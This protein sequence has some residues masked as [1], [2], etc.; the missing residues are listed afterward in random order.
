MTTAIIIPCYNAA[1]YLA[2]TL[3]S[4]RAQTRRDWHLIVVDDGSTDRTPEIASQ[5]ARN[6]ARIQV[7]RQENLG[8]SSAR[9][10]GYA[11]A[12][13][14]DEYAIFLDADD[15]WEPDALENLCEA[16]AG[17][18]ET[19]AAN[20]LHRVIDA[21]GR[22]QEPKGTP[23]ELDRHAAQGNRLIPWPKNEPAGFAALAYN[24]CIMTPGTLLIRRSALEKIALFDPSLTHAED[25]D[26][27]LRLSLIA[28]IVQIDR[29]VLRYRQHGAGA[30]ASKQRIHQG[31][32]AVRRKLAAMPGLSQEQR[33]I[34]RS[35]ARL[36]ARERSRDMLRWA[37]QSLRSGK[38][39]SGAKQL[40]HALLGYVS[41]LQ[42]GL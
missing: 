14:S 5:L 39:G 29:Y 9:N 10:N 22:L 33:R 4:V 16:L 21:H 11:R 32:L 28:P 35:S 41:Y 24:N 27:W 30:S 8:V 37:G 1:R 23:Y 18:P 2:E 19:P 36:A 42:G 38:V 25:W 7:I 17:A 31:E 15:L 34:A 12:D 3:E 13:A 6:D 26:V 40:R 20:G